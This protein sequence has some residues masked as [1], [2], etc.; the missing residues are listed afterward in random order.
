MTRSKENTLADDFRMALEELLRKAEMEDPDF[1]RDGVRVLAQELMDL[2]VSQHLGVQRYERS[3]ERRGHRNGTR[4]RP[5]DTRVGTIELSVPR[6]RDNTYFP[7]L[8]QPRKRAEQALVA[9]MQEAYI[10][11][12]STRRV[13]DLVQALVIAIGVNSRG[14]REVLGLDVE[15]SKS[16]AFWLSFL[17]SLV[18]RGLKGVRLVTSDAH[19]GLKGAIAAVL[20]GASWQGAGCIGSATPWHSCPRA[21]ADGGSDDSDRV[22]ATGCRRH[23]RAVGA[24]RRELSGTIRPGR[25]ADG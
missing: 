13:D 18:A 6:V 4:E 5:W 17:R 14:E 25:G 15:P 8:L 11:G 22:H 23:Q 10:H 1:L 16:G 12:V 7:S 19:E 9:V 24:G 20:H 21:P 3:P 2:E